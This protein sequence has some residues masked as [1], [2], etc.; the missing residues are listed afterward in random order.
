MFIPLAIMPR[1]VIERSKE[2]FQ[3]AASKIKSR[4]QISKNVLTESFELI[5]HET[6]ESIQNLE[7]GQERFCE[8]R[9]NIQTSS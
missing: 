2:F 5:S 7:L 6:L 3:G 4:F 8:L 1:S 9:P